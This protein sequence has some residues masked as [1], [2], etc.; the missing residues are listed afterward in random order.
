MT[1]Q[2]LLDDRHISDISECET[3]NS[4]CY[5]NCHASNTSTTKNIT[6]SAI[7]SD[8]EATCVSTDNN[9]DLCDFNSLNQNFKTV[10]E[11]SKP[12]VK[13]PMLDIFYLSLNAHQNLGELKPDGTV[14]GSGPNPVGESAGYTPPANRCP[15]PQT[16][17]ADANNYQNIINKHNKD[18]RHYGTSIT[19]NICKTFVHER[20]P[21][22]EA[23][24]GY[25]FGRITDTSHLTRDCPEKWYTRDHGH[26]EQYVGK[27]YKLKTISV[28]VER[29]YT[30][31]D[32]NIKLEKISL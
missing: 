18:T 24:R 26:L 17:I 11:P 15:S 19:H 3:S 28:S 10:N 25:Y 21:S 27:T 6:T 8:K 5:C 12:D 14:S 7:Q 20:D 30:D 22:N 2:Y 31:V 16:V 4:S 32:C 9:F 1:E 13:Y 29:G 23:S